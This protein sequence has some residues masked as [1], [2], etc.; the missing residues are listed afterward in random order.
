MAH[1]EESSQNV[2]WPVKVAP[3]SE[4]VRRYR[5]QLMKE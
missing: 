1:R 5:V 2:Y 3:Q 4:V